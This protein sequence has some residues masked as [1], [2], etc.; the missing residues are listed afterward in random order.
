MPAGVPVSGGNGG[1]SVPEA[2]KILGQM[3]CRFL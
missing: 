2:L 3:V 1:A